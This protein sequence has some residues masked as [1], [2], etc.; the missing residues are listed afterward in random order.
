M[1]SNTIA[2]IF[3]QLNDAQKSLEDVN[4]ELKYMKKIYNNL[5]AKDVK[6]SKDEKESINSNSK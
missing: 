1:D 3:K 6:D 5:D 2:E 4:A